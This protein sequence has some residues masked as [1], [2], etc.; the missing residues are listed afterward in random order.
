[1]SDYWNPVNIKTTTVY[2]QVCK[3][4][5]VGAQRDHCVGVVIKALNCARSVFGMGKQEEVC[6][7]AAFNWGWARRTYNLPKG[8]FN[9]IYLGE[10]PYV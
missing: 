4:V 8:F 2:E 1:M 10:N 5:P 6:I 3:A 9:K 7:T